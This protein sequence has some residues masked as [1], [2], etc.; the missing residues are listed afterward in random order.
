ML[1]ADV[2]WPALLL[3]DR[4]LTWW[5]IG[6]GLT[7]EFLI[8]RF[9]LGM[10]NLTAIMADILMNSV[11]TVAGIVLLPLAGVAWELFP[12]SVLY[13][14]LNV[15]TFSPVT[16]LATFGLAVLIN[17]LLEGAVLRV[18]FQMKFQTRVFLA[19]CLGNMVSVGLAFG[20]LTMMPGQM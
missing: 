20:S 18:A 12:G 16:W 13:S 10:P 15:G 2:I 1:L 6:A 9:W 5:A 11:S 17:T 3:E 14:I 7:A 4:L 8:L 19:L